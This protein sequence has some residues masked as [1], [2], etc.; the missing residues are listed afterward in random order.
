M[1]IFEYEHDSEP[2]KT[3]QGKFEVVQRMA[4]PPLTQCPACGQPCHRI[5][6]TFLVGGK[7]KEILSP[8]N[9]TAHGFTQYKKKGKGYYEKTAGPGPKSIVDGT[10]RGK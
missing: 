8:K 10:K 1:P 9:L 6:S 7:E 4:D 3:C 2:C 5:L